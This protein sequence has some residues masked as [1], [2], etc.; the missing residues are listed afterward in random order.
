MKNRSRAWSA[1][2]LAG[3][4]IIARAG[5]A[6]AQFGTPDGLP[7]VLEAVCDGTTGKAN[8]LC[9]AFCEAMDCDSAAPQANAA[10]CNKVAARYTQ[11]TGETLPCL[12]PCPCWEAAELQII[13][14]ENVELDG[15]FISC[16]AGDPFELLIG[17]DFEPGLASTIFDVSVTPA[18]CFVSTPERGFGI[19]IT[20]AQAAA[21]KEQIS[22]RCAAIGFPVP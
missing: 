1:A 3:V 16:D 10:A 9:V 2:A 22:D 19:R 7:P 21:C 14:A 12:R 13:T 6:A 18:V 20:P 11:I 4:L 17:T 8:G 15:P 5:A